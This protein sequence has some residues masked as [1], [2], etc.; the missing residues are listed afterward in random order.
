MPYRTRNVVNCV[1]LVKSYR[2]F[3]YGILLATTLDAMYCIVQSQVHRQKT[4]H[5]RTRKWQA[6]ILFTD[7]DMCLSVC[8]MDW[9]KIGRNDS[10]LHKST[11]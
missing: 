4:G 1:L 9:T 5:G 11:A 2:P 6:V 8:M 7:S 10:Y 3:L